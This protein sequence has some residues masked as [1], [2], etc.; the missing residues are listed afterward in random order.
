MAD[1]VSVARGAAETGAEAVQHGTDQGHLL[2]VSVDLGSDVDLIHDLASLELG[3]GRGGRIPVLKLGECGE[4][5]NPNGEVVRIEDSERYGAVALDHSRGRRDEDIELV[6]SNTVVD[7]VED[8]S[9]PDGHGGGDLDT[10]NLL[11][12]AS[13]NNDILGGESEWTAA[14]ERSGIRR[15]H[16]DTSH[17][18]GRRRERETR[19]GTPP[20][21]AA[22]GAVK[23]SGNGRTDTE[24]ETGEG[25]EGSVEV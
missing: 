3:D 20:D 23:A 1:G 12:A 2:R 6:G 7:T 19:K 22:K 21:I 16:A 5:R 9:G 14:G 17:V 24:V 25:D 11:E 15:V 8:D 4:L 10:D 13:G 18:D